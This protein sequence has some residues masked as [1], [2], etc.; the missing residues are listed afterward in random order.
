MISQISAYSPLVHLDDGSECESV[1]R[2]TSLRLRAVQGLLLPALVLINNPSTPA[3]DPGLFAWADR[4]MR[5]RTIQFF[6]RLN[7][8]ARLLSPL[9][10]GKSYT[11]V[12]GAGSGNEWL[13]DVRLSYTRML[14]Q[15][16]PELRN[17]SLSEH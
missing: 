10:D 9:A 11:S 14:L 16:C 15:L 1:S 6:G 17:L 12:P 2:S 7:P 5:G 13:E 4:T 3:R 8:H